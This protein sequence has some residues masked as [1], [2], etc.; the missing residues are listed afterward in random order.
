MNIDLDKPVSLEIAKQLKLEGFS[1]PT[2]YYHQEIN[3]PFCKGGLKR[4]K[5]GKLLNN[6]RYDDFIYSAP[7][8]KEYLEW[9]Q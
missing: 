6:N 8:E 1:I 4:N 5:N 2:E 9:K 7:T 3:L